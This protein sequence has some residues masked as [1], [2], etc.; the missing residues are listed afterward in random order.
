[1]RLASLGN[2]SK[3]VAD[4]LFENAGLSSMIEMRLSID[5][6]KHWKPHAA[7]YQYADGKLGLPA[8]EVTLLAAHAWTYK[9]PGALGCVARGSAGWKRSSSP[10]WESRTSPPTRS[11]SWSRA[12]TP[13][14]PPCLSRSDLLCALQFP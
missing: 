10:R 5:E 7:A 1:V 4:K 6:V 12:V 8:S 13:R 3:Q 2:G 14:T 9:G 11:P